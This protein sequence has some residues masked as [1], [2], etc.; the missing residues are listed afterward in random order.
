MEGGAFGVTV[1]QLRDGSL[2]WIAAARN[3]AV[4]P[5][6]DRQVDVTGFDIGEAFRQRLLIG[7]DWSSVPMTS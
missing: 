7:G 3:V 6:E 1:F 4:A 5:C 2:V